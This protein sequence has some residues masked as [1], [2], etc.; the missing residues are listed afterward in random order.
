M[1]VAAAACSRRDAGESAVWKHL[2]A[3]EAEQLGAVAEQIFPA[4]E[5]PGAL[6][7]G[8]LFFI[9]E[10]LGG[11]MSG[12]APQIKQGLA[13]LQQLSQQ[14]HGP[15]AH[16]AR[17]DFDQQTSLLEGIE[18]SPFFQAMTFLTLAGVFAMPRHGGNR[19]HAGWRMIGFEQRHAWLPPFGYYDALEAEAE[20][21]REPG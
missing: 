10:A 18:H 17:L 20:D 11:L 1:S 15:D 5:L 21:G 19:D 3:E 4:D 14:Q 6:E 16:F 7:I 12:V 8:V 9:D 13:E 2:T